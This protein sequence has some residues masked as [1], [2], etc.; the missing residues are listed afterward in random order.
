M[1]IPLHSLWMTLK[2]I[3]C[4]IR[5]NILH[6]VLS[7]CQAFFFGVFSCLICLESGPGNIMRNLYCIAFLIK[8]VGSIF[9]ILK[10]VLVGLFF[11]T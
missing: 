3:L 6:L 1:M 2:V 11:A 4:L 9:A 8:L 10:V 5:Y 7:V